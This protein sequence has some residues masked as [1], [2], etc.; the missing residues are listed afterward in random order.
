[1]EN[2]DYNQETSSTTLSSEEYE[3]EKEYAVESEEEEEY[4]RESEEEKEETEI[5][6]I[7][8]SGRVVKRSQSFEN[9]F[10]PLTSSSPDQKSH[11]GYTCRVPVPTDQ[12]IIRYH[13]SRCYRCYKSG[14]YIGKLDVPIGPKS[15]RCRLLFCNTC[16]CAIHNSCLPSLSNSYFDNGELTCVKCQRNTK[17]THCSTSIVDN[18]K[19]IPFRCYVCFRAFHKN[20]IKPGVSSS[21]TD[22]T[23]DLN[24]VRLYKNG[25]CIECT[26]FG[27]IPGSIVGER[28][29]DNK[30]ECLIKWKN[31]SY[32]HTNW[33]SDSW[34]QGAQPSAH[35]AYI[36]KREE[37]PS[38]ATNE[39]PIEWTIVDRILNVEWENKLQRIPRHILVVYKD[40]SYEDGKFSFSFL[41]YVC[42]CFIILTSIF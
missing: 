10:Y 4:T 9:E 6:T 39:I 12:N 11:T 38:I 35:R 36:K 34:M 28:V 15:R 18:S 25:K 27:T 16:S 40:T 41:F 1:M 23:D 42:V 13:S 21:L 32:R 20:C 3:S 30:K 5:S 29:V 31:A 22:K 14:T 26:T 2:D 19:T 7:S 17:C 37:N 8:R 24:F 33:V